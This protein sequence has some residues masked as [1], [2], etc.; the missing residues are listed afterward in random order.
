MPIIDAHAYL[1]APPE[2]IRRGTVDEL[3]KVLGQCR[4]NAAVLCSALAETGDFR[5][6]NEQLAQALAG[7]TGLHG[8]VTINPSYPEESIEEVR[9]RYG[10]GSI[11]AIKLPREAAGSR[12]D[13]EGF[14][15]VLQ[16]ALRYTPVVLVDTAGEADVRDT[17]T[18]AREFHTV[19]FVLGGMGE[20]DWQTAIRACAEV[21]NCY[22]EIGTPEADRDKLKDAVD[23][24]SAK[25][26]L[27]GSHFPRLHPMYV[28]GMLKDAEISDRDRDRIL[29]RNAAELF[30]LEVPAENLAPKG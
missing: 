4:V 1:G 27:F 15:A 16:S 14:R 18:L 20:Q 30:G 13:S 10:R 6:G 22:L 25:R 21:L 5:R 8:Y 7:R 12:I 23:G 29:W 26:L 24:V 11:V 3:A 19:R 17:V 9:Q 28:L 2:S